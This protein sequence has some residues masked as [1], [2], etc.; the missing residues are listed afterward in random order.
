M[1]CVAILDPTEETSLRGEWD[2]RETLDM[3]TS[4]EAVNV[5]GQEVVDETE[6]LHN[7]FILPKI[8]VSFEYKLIVLSITA[9]E[10]QPTRPL[11]RR[12]NREFGRER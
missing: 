2:D 5:D 9:S 1:E 7:P 6:K 11:L 3:Q 10:R 4:L 8:F 12:D